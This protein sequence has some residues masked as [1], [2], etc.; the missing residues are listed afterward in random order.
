MVQKFDNDSISLYKKAL[1]AYGI[2]SQKWML[3]EECGELTEAIAKYRRNR[4]SSDA[5]ITELVDVH[6]MIEQMA[7]FF[8]LVEFYEEKE[9]KLSR[10]KKRL[11]IKK[12]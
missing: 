12:E 3:I 9:R 6:I 1:Y 7:C 5:V 11:D 4:I 10:L 8:G 2:E